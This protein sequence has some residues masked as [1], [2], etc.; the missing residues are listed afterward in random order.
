MPKAFF[1]NFYLFLLYCY[2]SYLCFRHQN[3]F[4]LKLLRHI[5]NIFISFLCMGSTL[6]KEIG[7]K[8]LFPKHPKVTIPHFVFFCLFFWKKK[9]KINTGKNTREIKIFFSRLNALKLTRYKTKMVREEKNK[10]FLE[11]LKGFAS[12]L[13]LL[14][15]YIYIYICL[16][17]YTN[18]VK[19]IIHLKIGTRRKRVRYRWIFNVYFY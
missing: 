14:Y 3:I 19:F 5:S 9:E 10:I 2:L 15:I 1:L 16:T 12:N 7:V 8:V 13:Y 4:L 18:K 17:G 6:E 11:N